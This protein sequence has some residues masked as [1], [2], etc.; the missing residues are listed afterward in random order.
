[1]GKIPQGWMEEQ[2]GEVVFLNESKFNL[3]KQL[4]NTLI[5]KASNLI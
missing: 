3:V 1:M 5:S 4:K 2:W